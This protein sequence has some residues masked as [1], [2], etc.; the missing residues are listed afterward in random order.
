MASS[1][2]PKR[3]DPKEQGFTLS[4]STTAHED[5]VV[6]PSDTI[7]QCIEKAKAGELRAAK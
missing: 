4:D 1:K 2:R 5:D 6:E 7:V 3:S